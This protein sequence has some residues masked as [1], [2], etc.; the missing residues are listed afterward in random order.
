M[1]KIRKIFSV[2]IEDRSYD[3]FDIDGKE[4]EGWND[5]PKEW[6]LYYNQQPLP[7][8]L[9]PPLDSP[10]LIPFH[11]S[12]NRSLWDIKVTQHNY[13]KE[14][15]GHTQFRNSCSVELWCNKRLVYE[16][17]TGGDYLSFAFAKIQYLQVMLS[18]HPYNFFEPQKENGRKI[19]WYGLPAT[20]K[21]KSYTWE[22]GII[23]DY[24]AGLDKEAWWKEYKRRKSTVGPLSDSQK[25]DLEMDAEDEDEYQREDYINWGDALSD[26]HIGWF[27]E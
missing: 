9:F 19:Y 3:V 11:A 20:V 25:E 17:T 27:R 10:D 18:E 21:V 22:I 1:S 12:I 7:E 23:P 26:A 4:H 14:K 13:S 2:I 8:G 15:W 6:W 16:F 5:T 24:T